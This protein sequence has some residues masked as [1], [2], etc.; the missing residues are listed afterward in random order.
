MPADPPH[1]LGQPSWVNPD[2]AA[3]HGL[4]PMQLEVLIWVAR[5]MTNSA[6]ATRCFITE[7]SV[8]KRLRKVFRHLDVDCR[9]AAVV[10]AY[11]RGIFV[12][13]RALEAAEAA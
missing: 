10:A 9:V 3:R 5:G 12:P 7:E 8:R 2:L 13:R 6:I 11:D 4:T 1:T